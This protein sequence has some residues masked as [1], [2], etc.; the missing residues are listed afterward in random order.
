MKMNNQAISAA[1]VL[2]LAAAC[3]GP[4]SSRRAYA[5]ANGNASVPCAAEDGDEEIA[6][7]AIPAGVRAA[8]LARLPGFVI[9]GAE[10]ETE[11]G[12]LLYS[13]AGTVNGERHEIEVSATGA[14]L[15]VETGT[16]DEDD[17]DDEDDDQD[18]D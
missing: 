10:R 16:D 3:T 1:V 8:A 12:V 15:E 13:L 6:L 17:E 2:A 11:D 5:P 9:T 7:D 18:D 14:V 4:E